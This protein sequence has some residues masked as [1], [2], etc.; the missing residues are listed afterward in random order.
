MTWAV[1]A[2]DGYACNVL[3]CDKV[4]QGVQALSQVKQSVN[5]IGVITC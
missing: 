3:V 5:F 1:P 4:V 2:P